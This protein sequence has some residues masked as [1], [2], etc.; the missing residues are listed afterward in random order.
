MSR[1]APRRRLSPRGHRATTT[2]ALRALGI[3]PREDKPSKYVATTLAVRLPSS[4]SYGSSAER[5]PPSARPHRHPR[6]HLKLVDEGN[7]IS[8]YGG[9]LRGGARSSGARRTR[10]SRAG[11][12]DQE[13]IS[14]QPGAAATERAV[15][16]LDG[17]PRPRHSARIFA[18]LYSRNASTPYETVGQI[19]EIAK[20]TT[21][22][23]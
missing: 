10:V 14:E 4:A 1:R 23:M 13:S 2:A 19:A 9:R 16:H 18:Y 20:F 7:G 11:A 22:Q 21:V 5:A 12:S 3:R 17:Q 8:V 15:R 6:T